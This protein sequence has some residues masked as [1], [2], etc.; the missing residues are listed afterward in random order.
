[1]SADYHAPP[2]FA[3][4]AT[5]IMLAGLF[6]YVVKTNR[7]EFKWESPKKSEGVNMEGCIG[8][9]RDSLC[10]NKGEISVATKNGPVTVA[11]D[12]NCTDENGCVW[13]VGNGSF[14]IGANNY[15]SGVGSIAIGRSNCACN[16]T[17][18]SS[19]CNCK[20]GK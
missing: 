5:F 19:E 8:L 9:G 11:T 14:A 1:M 4:V 20:E 13:A 18:D 6:Y 3:I 7:Y 16:T 2:M 15:A 12:G 10:Q 17:S